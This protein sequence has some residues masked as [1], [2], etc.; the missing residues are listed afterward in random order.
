MNIVVDRNLKND[1]MVILFF[2]NSIC[3]THTYTKGI[4]KHHLGKD[5]S[6]FLLL[7]LD[8]EI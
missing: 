6:G 8:S 4:Q 1:L 5:K 2:L 7:P 3:N